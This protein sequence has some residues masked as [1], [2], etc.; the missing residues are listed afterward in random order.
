MH[1]KRKLTAAETALESFSK[2]ETAIFFLFSA[3]RICSMPGQDIFGSFISPSHV[4]CNLNS[5]NL[6]SLQRGKNLVMMTSIVSLP[7]S[8][9]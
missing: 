6:P 9:S 8:R 7:S 4:K 2:K 5:Q 1:Q 3:S